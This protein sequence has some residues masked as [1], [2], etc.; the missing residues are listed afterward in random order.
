MNPTAVILVVDDELYLLQFVSQM[1]SRAGYQVVTACDGFEALET[2]ETHPVDLI[3]A[4]INMPRMNGYQLY[5]RVTQDPRWVKIP[6]LFL[7]GRSQDSDIRYGKELGADD[8]LTKPFNLDDLLAA[9]RGR[10]RRAQQLAAQP[11]QPGPPPGRTTAM[12]TVGELRIDP[13]GHRAWLHGRLLSMSAREFKLLEYLARRAGEVVP[14][15]ELI[16]V[17]HGLKTDHAE[18]GDLLR[19]LVRSLRR[20]LGYPAGELGCIQSV[21]GVGYQLLPPCE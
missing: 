3:L 10:L 2:L 7:T 15:P 21:R 16:Q 5:E 17:T 6:F 9:V 1:L 14:L 12:L 13:A 18:A 4:D 8:Y 11:T 19:P 20:R